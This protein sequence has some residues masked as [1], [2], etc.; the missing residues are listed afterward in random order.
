VSAGASLPEAPSEREWQDAIGGCLQVQA[1]ARAGT[2][3]V[4]D[5]QHARIA[6]RL[7]A[8]PGER[9]LDL[10]CGVGHLL[11]WL[12]AHAPARCDGLDLSLGS[13]RAARR[14]GLRA[15]I[16]GD[17]AQLPLRAASYDAVV[18]NGSAHHLPDLP[19]ALAEI[20]R[21]LRPDGRLLLHEPVDSPWSG[22]VRQTLFRR[23]RY[24]SPADLA[25][26][27]AFTVAAVERALGDAG[28]VEVAS[29]AH[30]FLAYPLSGMYMG[31]PWSRS[32]RV[33]GALVALEERLA[34]VRPLRPLWQALAWRVLFSARRAP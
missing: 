14:G 18:C 24:E 22:A 20:H 19:A 6:A 25:H 15:L 26:K 17:A 9:V 4:L 10:G 7:A 5:R 28:F 3:L 30:D 21:V 27:H 13:L 12:G 8:A 1:Y 23:S 29:S 16:V 11:L 2:R 31:L 33:M 32:P 34:R